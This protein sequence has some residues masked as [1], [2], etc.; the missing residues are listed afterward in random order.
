MIAALAC[1]VSVPTSAADKAKKVA[2]TS[3]GL[4]VNADSV[5]GSVFSHRSECKKGRK[6]LLRS[7]AGGKAPLRKDVTNAKG[8]W[9]IAIQLGPGTYFAEIPATFRNGPQN[10]REVR[11]HCR[12]VK[13][14]PLTV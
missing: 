6:V 13:S 9:E 8:R 11:F 14:A 3:T 2:T 4:T 12:A 1:T 5:S 7:T 10:G